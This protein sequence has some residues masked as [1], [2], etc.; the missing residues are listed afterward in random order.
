MAIPHYTQLGQGF[1][2][3]PNGG[4]I[5]E[6]VYKNLFEITFVLPVILQAQQRNPLMLLQNALNINFNLT[7]FDVKSVQQRFKYSTREFLTTPN[8]TSGEFTIKFNVNVN[9]AG[10][11]E[12]WNTMKA[13]YDLLFNSQ[14]GTLHYKADMVG[15]VI[16]NQHDKKG[17]VLRRVTFQNV[18]LM[19]LQGYSLDWSSNDIVE[20]VE[21]TFKYDYFIDEYIDNNFTIAPPIISGY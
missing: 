4:A 1:G 16:V 11:M 18:Q 13:W 19:K 3:G 5:D 15:T 21:C 9:Q 8:Q 6:V 7:E 10:S 12:N 20:S 14:N 17:V 2:S